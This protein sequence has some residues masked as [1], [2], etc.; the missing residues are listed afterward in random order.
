MSTFKFFLSLI[1]ASLIIFVSCGDDDDDDDDDATAADDDSAP[2]DDDDSAPADDD[3]DSTPADDDNTVAGDDD[4]SGFDPADFQATVDNEYFPLTPGTVKTLEGE[5]DGE[6]IRVTTTVQEETIIIAGVEC[7]TLVE[8]EYEG[9]ELVEVSR[10]WFAQEIITGDVYY[11][12]EEVDDY[13]D[14]E[15]TG[16]G[17]AWKVGEEADFPGLIF[18]GDPQLGDEF[19]PETAPGTAYETAEIVEMGLDYSVPYDDF[20]DVIK[21]E[22]HDMG[23]GVEWKLYAPGIGLISELYTGGELPLVDIQPAP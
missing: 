18:P 10:N 1:L 11:F 2:V 5:E 17:G 21:V 19:S 4:A 12:G 8:E 16:H 9:E 23:G 7:T 22:E 3:D 6:I 13:A 14:G 15:I 20:S